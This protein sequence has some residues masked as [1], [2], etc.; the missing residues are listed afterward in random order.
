MQIQQPIPYLFQG[1][2]QK[3]EAKLLPQL[4]QVNSN[5]QTVHFAFGTWD[6]IIETLQQRGASRTLR[7][8]KYP[9]VALIHNFPEERGSNS[10]FY[11]DVNLLLVIAHHTKKEAKSAQRYQEVFVPVLLPIYH[12]LLRQMAHSPGIVQTHED[13]IQH[14]KIDRLD[15]GRTN[16]WTATEGKQL[17]DYV[18]A[19]EVR[20]LRLTLQ[21]THCSPNNFLASWQP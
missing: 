21:K 18:D 16:L 20:N 9:L 17:N 14:T 12:E 11:G 19:I 10:G 4:Q 6:E 8:Q 13:Q 2:V 1:L 5:I 7:F 3:V 15:W